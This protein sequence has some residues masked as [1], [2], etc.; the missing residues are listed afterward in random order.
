MGI[1][2][3]NFLIILLDKDFFPC[4]KLKSFNTKEVGDLIYMPFLMNM[5][6]KQKKE[7]GMKKLVILA[8]A[9]LL[10]MPVLSHAGSATSRWDL[11][12]GGYVMTQAG[13]ADQAV[14]S[15]VST[16]QRRSARFENARD[17]FG[18]LFA[19][20]EGRL[21]F[22]MRGP[23]AWGAKT[24]GRLEFDFLS[25]AAGVQGDG[26]LRHAYFTFDW[27]TTQLLLGNTWY[28]AYDV[29]LPP[30]GATLASLPNPGIPSRAPQIRLT[31]KL[32]PMFTATVGLEYPGLGKWMAARNDYYDN[33]TM[34]NWP[35]FYGTFVFASDVC[36]K[37]GPNMLKIGMSGVY[38]RQ[39]IIR[40]ETQNQFPGTLNDRTVYSRKQEDGWLA[41][42]FAYVPI[43]PQRE[44]NKAG[45]LAWYGGVLVGQG[46][47]NYN[48]TD[49]S[50]HVS[51]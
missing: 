43:I 20:V 32:G 37:I 28:G 18:N 3:L 16:A 24:G 5:V 15:G 30:G 46:L 41:H 27:P 35:N 9:V 7:D 8:I 6:L 50:G 51:A 31:Q 39:G 17:E 22:T 29:G 21:N 48:S 36:G 4:Y 14:G 45:A 1:N 33:Y 11:T 12:I 23:D 40:S 44:M 25:N 19:H 13:W 47:N 10:A 42:G 34:S 49:V 38:G 26:V 2:N